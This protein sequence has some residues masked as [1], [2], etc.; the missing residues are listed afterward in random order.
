MP[1]PQKFEKAP[2]EIKNQEAKASVDRQSTVYKS[3]VGDIQELQNQKAA[4]KR[5]IE[6]EQEEIKK[7]KAEISKKGQSM[8]SGAAA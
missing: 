1:S 7:I 6:K 2:A 3:S 5:M 4:Y 8:G